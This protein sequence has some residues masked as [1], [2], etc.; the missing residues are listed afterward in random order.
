M[1]QALKSTGGEVLVTGAFNIGEQL[2]ETLEKY[3]TKQLTC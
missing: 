1:V 2:F 3:L